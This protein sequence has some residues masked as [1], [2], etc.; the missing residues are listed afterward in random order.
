M[1][2]ENAAGRRKKSIHHSTQNKHGIFHECFY[3]YRYRVY[4][5]NCS[6]KYSRL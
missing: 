3:L 5:L 4:R 1:K 6:E 2:D